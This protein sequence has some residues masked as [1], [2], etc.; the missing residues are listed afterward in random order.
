M[1]ELDVSD[2]GLPGVSSMLTVELNSEINLNQRK[3]K[4]I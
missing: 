3:W 1:G 2:T 4:T